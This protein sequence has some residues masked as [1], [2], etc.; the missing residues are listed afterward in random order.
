MRMR[1]EAEDILQGAGAAVLN[2]PDF[3]GPE[4]HASILQRA[5][6]E[7]AAGKAVNWIGRAG[8]DAGARFRA[9]YDEGN[10]R[11]GFARGSVR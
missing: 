7:A 1:R 10:R 6:E 3:Y 11:A 4:V 2:L 8:G 9:R 5:L